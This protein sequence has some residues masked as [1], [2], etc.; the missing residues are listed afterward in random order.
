APGRAGR[1]DRQRGRLPGERGVAGVRGRRPGGRRGGI[2]A[3]G[4]GGET[5]RFKAD[6]ERLKKALAPAPAAPAA[7]VRIAWG[8]RPGDPEPPPGWVKIAW[9][10]SR[11]PEQRLADDPVEAI[12]RKAAEEN[13]P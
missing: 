13:G 8:W 2:E 1:A 12:I 7:Q 11:T 3:P 9:A 10:A 4:G 6:V 5:M